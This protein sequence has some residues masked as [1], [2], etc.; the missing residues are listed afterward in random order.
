MWSN[1]PFDLLLHI[2]SH[3]SP[4]SLARVNATC[5]NW[6]ATAEPAAILAAGRRLHPP[7]FVALPMRSGGLS[8]YAHNPI[9]HFNWIE[10]PLDH[11]TS[12]K[13]I[14]TISGLIIFKFTNT[15]SLN[16]ARC[17]PFTN[18]F[19]P[20]PPLNVARTNPA[21]GA[22][23]DS[24]NLHLGFKIYV[25]G[26]MSEAVGGGAASAYQATVEMY[27]S[28]SEK[29]EIIGAMPVEFAV[30][31]TVWSPNESVYSNGTL[32]WMTSARAYSVMGFDISSNRWRELSVPMADRLDFAVLVPRNGKL[33]VVG[34]ECG[35]DARVWEL[36]EGD[37][38]KLV[39]KVPLEL[40]VRLLGEKVNWGSVKCV[41]IEGGICLYKDVG[42]GVIIWRGVGGEGGWGWIE[43]CCA[44]RGREVRNFPIKGLLLQP[45][46][47]H[48]TF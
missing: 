45:N 36:G 40:G 33:A 5:R 46:L 20:L 17:N 15:T 19:R 42:S 48:S 34:G 23:E 47:A 32:Y 30:R 2:F 25:A 29:W 21:V 1:L 37:M 3:L 28:F 9:E 39:G 12:I 35:G 27:D 26:G 4:E 44:I 14:A 8:C 10:L 31:L 16:L 38:W 7:W 18:Q 22:V 41:G 11:T 6:H 24:W 43:G 13:P